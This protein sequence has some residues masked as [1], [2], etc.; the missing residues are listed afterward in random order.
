MRFFK[1]RTQYSNSLISIH[2][3]YI[4]PLIVKY[5]II[6]GINPCLNFSKYTNSSTIIIYPINERLEQ[7]ITGI[8]SIII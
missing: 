5:K 1:T 4:I 3:T 2:N 7:N 8:L 6:L